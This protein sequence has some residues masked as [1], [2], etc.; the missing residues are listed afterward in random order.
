[1]QAILGLFSGS[2]IGYFMAKL[3]SGANT[4]DIGLIGSRIFRFGDWQIHFHHWLAGFLLL[5][6]SFLFFRKRYRL[7]SIFC[8]FCFGIFI[9]LMIQGIFT[10]DDWYQVLIKN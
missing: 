8:T 6:L 7:N 10:Y 2:S 5:V 3:F 4:G 1:M 9:G